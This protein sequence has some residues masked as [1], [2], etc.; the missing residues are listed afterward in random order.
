MKAPRKTERPITSPITLAV[1]AVV[2]PASGSASAQDLREAL[3][4]A[5]V[6]DVRETTEDDPGGTMAGDAV[7]SGASLLLA[8]GGDGTVRA[9]LE[10][11][12]GA[13]TDLG[14]I[15]LGTGNLLAGNLDLPVGLEALAVALSP[16]SRRLDLGVVNGEYFAVMAGSGFDA[17]MIRDANA[18]AKRRFGN[19]AYVV[20]AA[21]HLPAGLV[22]TRVVVNEVEVWAGRTAMVLVGNCSSVTG[23]L[24]V[25]PDAHPDDG[26]L[27]V[28]VLSART[29]SQWVSVVWRLLRGRSQRPDLVARF[30]GTDI[31]VRTNQ[32]RP[33]ELD[34]EDR[35]ASAE[36][37]FSIR[38]GALGVR[39]GSRS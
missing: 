36:L 16:G 38:P 39:V 17:L 5:G 23:G 26:L 34:G 14:I 35:P 9:C 8:C 2:N 21:R 27:D 25:F 24:A 22:R 19:I 31:T 11:L 6:I 7:A 28:A 18:K 1:V 3:E 20:S 32:P 37:I 13:A 33:Y 10:P 12:D 30:Q 15:P 29:L 4:Q